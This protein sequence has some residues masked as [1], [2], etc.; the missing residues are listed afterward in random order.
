MSGVYCG[1]CGEGELR[2]DPGGAGRRPVACD[3]CGWTTD[4][5]SMPED[6]WADDGSEPPRTKRERKKA[7]LLFFLWVDLDRVDVETAG[8]VMGVLGVSG[9]SVASRSL[10]EL[11]AKPSEDALARLAALPGVRGVR[12]VP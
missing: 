3:I 1:G 9:M 8:R 10:L 5:A 12:L 2:H 11:A 6:A 7:G 4:K